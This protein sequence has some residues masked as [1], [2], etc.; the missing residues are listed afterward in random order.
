MNEWMGHSNEL[1]QTA[2]PE[3]KTKQTNKCKKHFLQMHI[4]NVY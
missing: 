1:V 2:V 4:L 3:Q